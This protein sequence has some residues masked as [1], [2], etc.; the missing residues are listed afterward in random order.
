MTNV[1][2]TGVA[3]F[4]GSNL[5]AYHLN[6]GDI[7]YGVDSFISS[8]RS[9]RHLQ[10]LK[11]SGMI[12][13][14]Q[15]VQKDWDWANSIESCEIIYNFACPASPPIYQRFPLYTMDTCYL[16]TKNVLDYA[17]TNESKVIHASTS[18][19]YGDP[20]I[21]PQTESYRGNVNT[22]GI[23]ANYDEGKRIAE[24][25]CFEYMRR[26]ELDV[27]V[28]RIFN[29][30]GPNMDPDDGRVVTNFIKQALKNEPIT[31]YGD[32]LQTRSFCYIDDLIRAATY[33]AENVK[34]SSPINVGNPIEFT[35]IELAHTVID[36]CDSKSK[37]VYLPLPEDDPLQRK[38]DISKAKMVLNWEPQVTLNEGLIKMIEYMRTVT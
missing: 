25:L 23:R 35:M 28:F 18:E 11:D 4:I 22:W 27:V 20:N 1:L 14:E 17:I 32:G 6:K 15:H 26:L 31:I 36:L 38:P 29:T 3:G 2:I 16:G 8:F 13:F 24:T 7:V 5:A 33:A 19:V 34:S 9:N 30:Y 21:S 12:F 37:I 10:N